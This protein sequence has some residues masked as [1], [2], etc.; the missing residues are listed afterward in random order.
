MVLAGLEQRRASLDTLAHTQG[1]LLYSC[2]NILRPQT[3]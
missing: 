1:K 2:G 3:L